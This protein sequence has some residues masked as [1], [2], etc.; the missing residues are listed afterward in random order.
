MIFL[1]INTFFQA[2]DGGIRTFY[3]EKIA[4]FKNHPQHQYYLVTA[5]AR[6]QIENIA[7]NVH[8][9]YV[10]GLKGIIGKERVLLID[11]PR[12]LYLIR[13]VKPD[14]IEAGDPLFTSAFTY[15]LKS[16]G[17]HKDLLSCFHHTDPVKTYVLPWASA[18]DTNFLRKFLAFSSQKQ[19]SFFHKHYDCGLVASQTMK[20]NLEQQGLSNL[21]VFPLGVQKIFVENSRV[22]ERNEK[23]ML[24]AGRLE[25]EKGIHLLMRILPELLDHDG[26]QVT[27]MGKG[28]EENCFA[29]YDHPR[30]NYLGYLSQREDVEAVFNQH[31]IF[32]AP[33]PFET[34]GIAAS[35]A[36]ANGM[37]VIGPDVG[38]TGE[39]LQSMNSPFV[40]KHDNADSFYRTILKALECDMETESRNSVKKSK[41]F[42]TWDTAIEKMICF[43]QNKILERKKYNDE[44]KGS[45]C[46]A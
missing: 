6:N 31:A 45:D 14:V 32:L 38:G 39:L 27:V 17:L 9:V 37:V 41:D 12:I 43:Y 24:F 28:R 8:L 3:S 7:P 16:L 30:L 35:E 22:R 10:F 18:K 26:V 44:E 4:W 15:V 23:R 34:F 2:S 25:P 36:V 21:E 20:S 13:K 19:F 46:P 5:N 11:Y 33:G 42:L 40:F 29:N 1:D